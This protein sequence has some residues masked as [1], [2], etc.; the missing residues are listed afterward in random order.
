MC[1]IYNFRKRQTGSKLSKSLQQLSGQDREH[2]Y[3][4]WDLP[5]TDIERLRQKATRDLTRKGQVLEEEK[6]ILAQQASALEKHSS[7]LISAGC[8]SGKAEAACSVLIE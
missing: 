6:A 5:P 2:C 8:Y 4:G 1:L 7:G 3:R